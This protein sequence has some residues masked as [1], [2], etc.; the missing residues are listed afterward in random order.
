MALSSLGYGGFAVAADGTAESTDRRA[1]GMY[2]ISVVAE[3]TGLGAHTLRGYER[4]GLLRPVRTPGGMRLYSPRDVT[5][6][7]RAAALAAD[8]INLAGVRRILELE[9]EVASLR[10]QLDGPPDAIGA[11]EP[12]ASTTGFP[13]DPA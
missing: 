10:A 7:R 6:V 12:G 11:A 4:A 2:P 13:G 3:M 1:E 8:G 9:A 5:L